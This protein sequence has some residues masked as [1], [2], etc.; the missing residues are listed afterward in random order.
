[1]ER[2]SFITAIRFKT[3]C[4]FIW[5]CIIIDIIITI[6]AAVVACAVCGV[7]FFNVG[8]AHRK[9]IAEAEFGSAE[10][11]AKAIVSDA[12]RAAEARKRELM[13]EAKEENHKLRKELDSEVKERRSEL[14]RQ[15]RRLNQKEET[16]DKKTDNLERKN[17][18]LIQDLSSWTRRNRK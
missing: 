5:G 2:K 4:R 17:S 7:V 14:N 10:E 8:V 15:E 9:K 18:R 16:L 11:K 6:A 3:F 12:E 1:M 13:L